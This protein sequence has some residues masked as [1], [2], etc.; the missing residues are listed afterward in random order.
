MIVIVSGEGF[1]PE[2]TSAA[3]IRPSA[4]TLRARGSLP[5]FNPQTPP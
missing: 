4:G 2:R 1:A 3:V 5:E